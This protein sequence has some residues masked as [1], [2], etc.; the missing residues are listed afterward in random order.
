MD[1]GY[2]I[3]PARGFFVDRM[4]LDEAS[5]LNLLA[6]VGNVYDLK[7]LQRA[8]IVQDRALRKPWENNPAG[9]GNRGGGWWKRTLNTANVADTEGD[10]DPDE[11]GLGEDEA[12]PEDVA[13]ELYETFYDPR[14]GQ[15]EVP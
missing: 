8:A 14:D 11:L 10:E 15:A 9:R 6:S 4:G 7:M 2:Q 5:E 3:L 12:V 13:E 1:V